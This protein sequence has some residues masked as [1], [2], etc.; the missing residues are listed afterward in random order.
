MYVGLSVLRIEGGSGSP[1]VRRVIGHLQATHGT[2]E[3][4]PGAAG[5]SKVECPGGMFRGWASG[6]R[7]S[8]RKCVSSF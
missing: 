4:G 3:V 6:G 1:L 2:V 7:E 5:E 8:W